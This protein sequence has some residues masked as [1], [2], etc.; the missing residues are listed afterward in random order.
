MTAPFL[1]S[2]AHIVL[3]APECWAIVPRPQ[4]GTPHPGCP[5]CVSELTGQCSQGSPLLQVVRE[6]AARPVQTALLPVALALRLH[7]GRLTV[8]FAGCLVAQSSP[9]LCNPLDCSQPSFSVRGIFFRQEHWNRLPF[10]SP[11]VLSY[12]GIESGTKG[13]E[14][15]WILVSTGILEPVLLVYQGTT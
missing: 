4:A 13:L 12:P 1:L 11:G 6:G 8:C 9:A 15:P 2:P 14:H 3:A 10:P 7:G 5:L